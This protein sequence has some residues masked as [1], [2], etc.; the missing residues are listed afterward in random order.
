MLRLRGSG[1]MW[2][3]ERL[4]NIAALTLP[5]SCTKI[6][7]LEMTSCSKTPIGSRRNLEGAGDVL[8]SCSRSTGR[9]GFL[10]ASI[11]SMA[12]A[13]RTNLCQFFR[14]HAA[15]SRGRASSTSTDIPVSP[16]QRGASFS[17]IAACTMLA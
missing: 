12:A 17:S 13:R 3:K 15:G 4:L 14:E 1:V 5:A 16:G 11:S 6:A 8:S 9:S 10:R 2:Q 7:W